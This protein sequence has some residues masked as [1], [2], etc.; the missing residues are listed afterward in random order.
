MLLGKN[1]SETLKIEEK[2]EEWLKMITI[3]I[4]GWG[5]RRVGGKVKQITFQETNFT[6]LLELEGGPH[7]E[8]YNSC[9]K[10]MLGII[11]TMQKK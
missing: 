6:G 3:K 5:E 2:L 10:P 1:E 4:G 7:E 9:L 11:S 8:P